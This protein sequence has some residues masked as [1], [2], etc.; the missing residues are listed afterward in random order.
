[1]NKNMYNIIQNMHR[2]YTKYIQNIYKIYKIYTKYIQIYTILY[3]IYTK[4]AQKYIQYNRRWLAGRHG[5]GARPK[6]G[7]AQ[8]PDLDRAAPG[9]GKARPGRPA[10]HRQLFCTYFSIFCM[11]MKYQKYIPK[12]IQKY[13]K[14]YK[15]I[16]I[17]TKIY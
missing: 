6:P 17:Y 10:T 5:P 11:C 4:Y 8:G 9:L 7:A 13:T 12:Y 16:P 1:M 3:K 14:I 15:N 2:I